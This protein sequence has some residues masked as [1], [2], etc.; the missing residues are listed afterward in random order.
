MRRVDPILAA[1]R[2]HLLQAPVAGHHAG[3]DE[4]ERGKHERRGSTRFNL[5]I[6]KPSNAP[7]SL[8]NVGLR[9]PIRLI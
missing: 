3:R 8:K 5:F 4:H 6:R 9:Q 7:F 1:G 2:T